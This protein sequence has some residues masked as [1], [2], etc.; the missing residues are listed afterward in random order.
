MKIKKLLLSSLAVIIAISTATIGISA[1][2]IPE[3]EAFIMFADGSWLSQYFDDDSNY[4]SVMETAKITGD[5]DYS[6]KV[7]A[8]Q[9]YEDEESGEIVN[10]DGANGINFLALG[11]AKGTTKFGNALITINKVLLDGEE[12]QLTGTPFTSSDDEVE[13]RSNLYNTWV[14]SPPEDART[15]LDGSLAEDAAAVVVS[16]DDFTKEWTTIQID[17]TISGIKTD[18]APSDTVP[19]TG[20]RDAVGVMAIA[21]LATGGTVLSRKKK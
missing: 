6:V 16:A 3:G 15:S 2:E 5:G 8:K 12:I 20:V 14:S 18:Q 10:Q 21:I 19:E 13:L 9:E 7:T 1:N 17:F 4:P 11:I